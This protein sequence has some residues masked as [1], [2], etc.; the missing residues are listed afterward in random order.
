MNRRIAALTITAFA[1]LGLTACTASPAPSSSSTAQAAPEG[2]DGQSVADACALI[3]DTM[4]QATEDF[5]KAADDPAAVVG[6]MKSAADE[7]AAAADEITNKDV[8]AVLPGVQQMFADTAEIMQG[9]V[10]GDVSKIA[11]LAALGETFQS[12]VQDFQDLCAAG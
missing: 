10:D 2:G 11:D 1:L 4:Q 12:T 9:I 6:A 7:L 5:G 3:Q 8:A